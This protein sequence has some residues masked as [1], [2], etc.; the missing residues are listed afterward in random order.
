MA[1]T[2]ALALTMGA[3][4]RRVNTIVKLPRATTYSPR[5]F[6]RVM[7]S[8][9]QSLTVPSYEFDMIFARPFTISSIRFGVAFQSSVF[10]EKNRLRRLAQDLFWLL[11][12]LGSS[13]LARLFPV[14]C[15]YHLVSMVRERAR[16]RRGSAWEAHR[17]QRRRKQELE[18]ALSLASSILR[19]RARAERRMLL[20]TIAEQKVGGSR[21][22]TIPS[23]RNERDA[24]PEVELPTCI[25]EEDPSIGDL[26][27]IE[28]PRA[29]EVPVRVSHSADNIPGLPIEEIPWQDELPSFQA[30]KPT[31]NKV[32]EEQRKATAELVEE[33]DSG[34]VPR[35][36]SEGGMHGFLL[37]DEHLS[38]VFELRSHLAD[39]ELRMLLMS[40]RLDILLS[41]FSGAPAQHKC[42]MCAQE[43]AIPTRHTW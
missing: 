11:L 10:W 21:D 18:R 25:I 36:D 9:G 6:S 40:Q 2:H 42:P 33:M 3:G 27:C 1:A 22:E 20:D 41:A 23:V 28:V 5:E 12:L 29:M 16:A 43:F 13:S 7:D 19:R 15:T 30:E 35:S 17:E 24:E 38:L 14:P 34:T 31:D 26:P 37:S 8:K 32:S 39:M 4:H